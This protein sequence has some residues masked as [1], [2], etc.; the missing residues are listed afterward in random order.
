MQ[1][2]KHE[3]QHFSAPQM[4]DRQPVIHFPITLKMQHIFLLY[5]SFDFSKLNKSK[6]LRRFE[7]IYY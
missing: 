1:G 3:I 5:Y 6:Y 4:V 7:V 2:E